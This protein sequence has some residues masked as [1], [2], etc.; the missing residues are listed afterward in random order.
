MFVVKT[1]VSEKH[2]GL[3][4]RGQRGLEENITVDIKA[5]T[6]NAVV[7]TKRPTSFSSVTATHYSPSNL[8]RTAKRQSHYHHQI[9]FSQDV[10]LL[11][12]FRK[13]TGCARFASHLGHD[14]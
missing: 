5:E 3:V 8:L 13:A 6:S 9:Q 2:F 11:T 14:Y 10:R 1:F 4:D 12:F 7:P